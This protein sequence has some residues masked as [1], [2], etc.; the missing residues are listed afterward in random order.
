MHSTKIAL[1][2]F[3][4][5]S[6]NCSFLILNCF[7]RDA[8]DLIFLKI[9]VSFCFLLIKSSSCSDD[10]I[11]TNEDLNLALYEL[12]SVTNIRDLKFYH[13]SIFGS[14]A[15]QKL[16]YWEREHSIRVSWKF[17]EK[18]PVLK[19]QYDFLFRDLFTYPLSL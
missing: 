13:N 7:Q 3:L 18:I 19:K 2:A 17:H 1:T 12:T 15:V 5:K 10:V 4:R 8:I 16:H 14:K 11:V 9:Q 6:Q